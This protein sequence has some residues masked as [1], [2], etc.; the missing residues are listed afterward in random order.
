M[1]AN[2]VRTRVRRLPGKAAHDRATL[3]AVLD[4]ASVAHVGITQDAQPYVLP[5][6]AA[7]DGDRLLLHGSRAS[8]LIT[9][10]ASGAPACA[11]V[12]ML[13]G[14]VYARSA[15]ES[16]MHYRSATILGS[17][18]PVAPDEVVDALRVLTE[19]LMPGRWSE[20]RE[21]TRKELAATLVLALPL[22]EWSV[23][24]SAGPPTDPDEDL[25]EPVWA[26][27]VPLAIAAGTPVDAPDLAP[28]RP[29]PA[30]VSEGLPRLAPS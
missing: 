21:P 26:G 8:R 12:T 24:I 13:D 19:H 2:P 18:A 11:T 25:A 22:D 5:M 3:D 6:A 29:V 16:S 28:D 7:R 1:T 20:L 15:F 10:L 27:V 17:A 9:T 14:L 23:K 30:Y 4:A